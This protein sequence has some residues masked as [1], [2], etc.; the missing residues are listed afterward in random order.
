[1]RQRQISFFELVAKTV[2]SILQEEVPPLLC[3]MM[4]CFD[5]RL[6]ELGASKI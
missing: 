1:M 4:A 5:K 3:K 2:D 6:T